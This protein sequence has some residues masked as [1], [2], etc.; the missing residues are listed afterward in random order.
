MSTEREIVMFQKAT[1]YDLKRIIQESP[2][3]TFTKTELEA[4]FDAYIL[5][6][7]Q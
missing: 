4:L 7:E 6:I 3:E 2:N 1:V 5:G